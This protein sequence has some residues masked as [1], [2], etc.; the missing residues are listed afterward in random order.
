MFEIKVK[1]WY[2][3]EVLWDDEQNEVDNVRI[4]A[5]IRSLQI[6]KAGDIKIEFKT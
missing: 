4:S 2:K 1:D 5:E 6:V 3:K